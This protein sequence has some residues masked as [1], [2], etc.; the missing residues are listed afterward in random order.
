MGLGNDVLASEMVA[1]KKLLFLPLILFINVGCHIFNKILHYNS[2]CSVI[3]ISSDV[4]H[5]K[6]MVYSVVCTCGSI[7]HNIYPHEENYL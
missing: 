4:S 2:E 3:C 1:I 5:N 7:D 6:S